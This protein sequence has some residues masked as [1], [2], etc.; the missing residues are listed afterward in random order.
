ML[1]HVTFYQFKINSNIC[2]LCKC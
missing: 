2:S 1:H